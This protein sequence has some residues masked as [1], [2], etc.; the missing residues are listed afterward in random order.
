MTQLKCVLLAVGLLFGGMH[1]ASGQDP[2]K[3]VASQEAP[4]PEL[5]PLPPEPVA[6]A[7][8]GV[9]APLAVG[10]DS[11]KIKTDTW[12]IL[13]FGPRS[14]VG[15]ALSSGIRMAK[16]NYNY[17]N[18]WHQGM[19]G[20][21]RIYGSAYGTKVATETARYAASALLREDYRYV[22]SGSTEFLPRVFHAVGFI[23]VDRSDSGKRRLA[24][25]NFA[26][27]AAGGFVPNLWLPDGFNDATHGAEKMGE[28]FGGFAIQNVL[29]EFT[30]DIFRLLHG[31]HFP[32]PQLP[33]PE[34]WT[35]DI[36]IARRPYQ[37]SKP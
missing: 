37:I 18:D 20:Y 36:S 1:L 11:L 3:P 9:Y 21:G 17:P 15:P 22:P 35:K 23:F 12:L 5:K 10:P 2:Q 14:L 27:A 6:L 4:K 24:Y 32:F 7:G 25:S 16:P 33:V 19:Q 29:R 13:S 28:R 31:H 26:G 30:P 34:W 8:T